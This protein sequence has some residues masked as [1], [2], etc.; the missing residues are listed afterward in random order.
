MTFYNPKVTD[1]DP[2]LLDEA[3]AKVE[4]FT[5]HFADD[6]AILSAWG[7]HYFCPED[8]GRLIYDQDQPT[9]HRCKCCGKAYDAEHLDRT[10]QTFYRNDAVV[11][12]LVAAVVY[13]AAG[14]ESCLHA[15]EKLLSFYAGRYLEFPIHNK[16]DLTF[17][18]Y[19][20]MEWGCGRIM[21][22]GLNEAIVAIR[23]AQAMKVLGN[24]ASEELRRSV[25]AMFRE[26][27]QL[28]KP[29]ATSIH[30]ISCW[31]LSAIGVMGFY[32][33]DDEMVRF[34]FDSEFGMR[35]Q[36]REGVTKDG[37]WYEG[38]IHYNFFLLEGVSFLALFAHDSGYD[39]G[40]EELAV[41]SR[42]LEQAYAYAFDGGAFPTPNDGWPDINLKT[43]LHVYHAFAR[44]FGENSVVGE[45]VKNIEADVIPRMT[46]PMSEPFYLGQTALERLMFNPDFD[47]SR[48]TKIPRSSYNYPLSNFA[49]LRAGR[50]NVFLK[51]GLNGKSHAHP[52]IMNIEI[53]YDGLRLSRDLSN[54]GYSSR[55]CQEWH[56]KTLAHNTVVMNGQDMT[57]VHP[58]QP[59]T[60]DAQH[61]AARAEN[62]YDGVDYE[63][64]LSVTPDML[65]DA[66]RVSTAQDATFDYVL[67][68]EKDVTLTL[69]EGAQPASL[70]YAE[71]GY[72]YA[73]DV[74]ICPEAPSLTLHA[75]RGDTQIDI[76]IA[77][78]GG[79]RLYI[80]RTPDNP[81]GASRHTLIV[82]AQGRAPGFAATM[83]F[84]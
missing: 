76:T 21:P 59:L 83:T 77:L 3:K 67:H 33:Q 15:A 38:S 79:K 63:R 80:C 70:G 7:H 61:I 30:N 13:R 82:R 26:A 11:T 19:A 45:L 5:A 60:F 72:Q 22:Q 35:R 43:Y 65:H 9:I 34:A 53:S 78:D 6:P 47:Y 4:K 84:R 62:V 42:M 16:K 46:L 28:L 81:I 75:R 8:G 1:I 56:R 74:R 58:G 49:M 29:Q 37:F 2:A 64:E 24:D 40:Q 36:L 10:W 25:A 39:F 66:F 50:L 20:S 48:F 44:V 27:W 55:L 52:D 32:L 12:A 41:L 31:L 68:L 73:G 71:H 57:S 17:P 18:D 69:P 14:D 23:I 51:Y 54:A